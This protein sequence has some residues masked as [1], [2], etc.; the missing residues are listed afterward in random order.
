MY[1]MATLLSLLALCSCT[2]SSE[3]EKKEMSTEKTNALTSE[4]PTIKA[5][6]SV[7][8]TALTDLYAESD[9]LNKAILS[10]N[11]QEI[12]MKDVQ[13]KMEPVLQQYRGRIPEEQLQQYMESMQQQVVSQM[14]E[15]ILIEGAVAEEKIE[16][17]PAQIDEFIKEQEAMLP[18]GQTLEMILKAQGVDLE[19][20]KKDIALQLAAKEL[21]D[22]KTADVSVTDEEAK[23]AYEEYVKTASTDT[24][25]VTASHI[26]IKVDETASEEEKAASKAKLE[27]IRNDIIAGTIT[28]EDAAKENSDCPSGARAGGS[29]GTF[30]KGQMVP[31]FEAAA[32]SQKAGEVGPIIETSF[33]YHIIKVADL[34]N[35]EEIKEELIA[36]KKQEAAMKFMETLQ[37]SANIEKF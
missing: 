37:E 24:N 8:Q 33:G 12:T 30:G 6:T 13:E 25:S 2:N 21:F 18:E 36:Q 10:V 4:N 9:P 34:K 28:F 7:A 19:T 32:F 35:L 22:R 26:L 16:V 31:E 15:K 27:A 17:T 11:G 1:R 20:V 3:M 14:V 29:L 23:T 5:A